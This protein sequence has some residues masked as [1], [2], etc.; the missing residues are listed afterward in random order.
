MNDHEPAY[1]VLAWEAV[2]QNCSIA[3]YRQVHTITVEFSTQRVNLGVGHFTGGA[4][5][6]LIYINPGIWVRIRP[7]ESY[8]LAFHRVYGIGKT[9]LH[10]GIHYVVP[11]WME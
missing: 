2:R 8:K 9:G 3:I 1:R 4:A 6:S 10:G 5:Q 11:S 7:S